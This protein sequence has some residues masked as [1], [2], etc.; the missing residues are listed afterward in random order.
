MKLINIETHDTKIYTFRNEEGKLYHVI[1]QDSFL[2]NIYP[3]YRFIGPNQSEIV[4]DETINKI[5]KVMEKW[6]K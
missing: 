5:K 4:D 3:E 6:E 2:N 1:K